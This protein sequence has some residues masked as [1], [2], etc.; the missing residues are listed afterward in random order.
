MNESPDPMKGLAKFLRD[1]AAMA[2]SYA[3][4]ETAATLRRWASE[5][6]ACRQRPAAPS[7]LEKTALLIG[8]ASLKHA[9][10]QDAM[11][12]VVRPA[13]DE[14]EAY[15]R[16][17]AQAEALNSVRDIPDT[18]LPGMWERADFEGGRD[19]IREPRK[20]ENVMT[21][22][23]VFKGEHGL[24]GLA[25]AQE[26]WDEQPYG[27]RLY[28]GSGNFDYLHRDVLRSAV[29][30]LD[31]CAAQAVSAEPVAQSSGMHPF[32]K[33][34]C[35]RLEARTVRVLPAD[36]WKGRECPDCGMSAD[37][38]KCAFEKGGY[39][40]RR[41]PDAYD[42]SPYIEQP[43]KDCR[44]AAS[45]IRAL[46]AT[47]TGERPAAPA[48]DNGWLFA[49]LN[50]IL[51]IV[52][53]AADGEGVLSQEDARRIR[54]LCESRTIQE[55][56]APAQDDEDLMDEFEVNELTGSVNGQLQDYSSLA[57]PAAVTD[58]DAVMKLVSE[59]GVCRF[60]EGM[61]A[62]SRDELSPPDPEIA[63]NSKRAF[64]KVRGALAQASPPQ[65]CVD[66]QWVDRA[67]ELAAQWGDARVAGCY[68]D[69]ASYDSD[70]ARE[71]LRTH[72]ST[73]LTGERDAS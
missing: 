7:W 26:F 52:S 33:E 45:L 69:S 58:A 41:D 5:V 64:E 70:A 31:A 21:D 65:P 50:R 35:E 73:A 8:W 47:P 36:W 4:T 16:S 28:Y 25:E 59:Y 2:E 63:E 56:A 39:C 29:D 53:G 20:A 11:R 18:E 13:Q 46:C 1:R 6:E 44:R 9:N 60:C 68:P 27:K 62:M 42:D 34:L 57:A 22:R 40:Q 66:A 10:D 32:T 71:D 54:L 38:Q 3:A 23:G 48:P 37:R 30:A 12:N 55:A 49:R 17:A 43:D 14:F 61:H 51:E 15:R 19:E 24:R 72:L 67:M